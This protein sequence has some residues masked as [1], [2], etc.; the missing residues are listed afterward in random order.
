MDLPTRSFVDIVRDMSA[1][2]TASAG[3]LIDVSVGSVLRAIIEANAAIVLWVQWL[4]LL[5]LQATRA[6]TCTG[7]DLDSWMADF[8][9][10][11]L[12]AATASGSAT[13]SRFSGIA[14]TFVPAGML[15]KTQDGLVSFTVSGDPSNPAWQPQLATYALAPGVLAIDLPIAAVVAGQAGNVL[16]STITMLASAVPGVDTVNNGTATNG[17]HDPETDQAFRSRFTNFFASRSRATIDAIGYAISLVGTDLSYVILENV[18][19]VGNARPG[20]MLIVVDDGSGSLAEPLLTSLSLAVESVRPV[21]TTF[22]IQPPQTIQV[23]VSLSVLLPVD[24]SL[25]ATQNELQSAIQSYIG[26]LSI[27]TSLSIT[28]ISQIAYQTEVRIIN[29]AN[30]TLNG[31]ATDLVALPTASF[32]FQ[33]VSFI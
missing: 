23:Q 29:V 14:P 2:M 20:N 21:G 7:A 30:V 22:T 3:R 25:S 26:S 24:L 33:G 5:A 18:D 11:R 16:A 9:F 31:Q 19:A 13:F 32:I 8:S 12:P 17:G 28:R 27:G 1:G 10:S 6:S 4:V 15:L